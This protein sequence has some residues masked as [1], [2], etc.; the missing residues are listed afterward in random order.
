M[1]NTVGHATVRAAYYDHDLLWNT[2]VTL[3]FPEAFSVQNVEC[4]LEIDE[5]NK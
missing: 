5:I 2:I 3:K 1:Y 4:F